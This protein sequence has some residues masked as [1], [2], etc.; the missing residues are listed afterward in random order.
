MRLKGL[1]IGGLHAEVDPDLRLFVDVRAGLAD[2]L[3]G[4]DAD[5]ASRNALL[6]C[7][8]IADRIPA[9]ELTEKAMLEIAIKIIPRPTAVLTPG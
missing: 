3:D 5:R 1:A 7:P 4:P 8:E 6:F 9:K 2:A